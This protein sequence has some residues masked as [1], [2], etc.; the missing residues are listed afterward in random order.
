MLPDHMRIDALRIN[1][2]LVGDV[3]AEAQAV[4]KG[5]GREDAQLGCGF[6]RDVRERVGRIGDD[7][8][9]CVRRSRGW[10]RQGRGGAAGCGFCPRAS[11]RPV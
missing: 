7:K 6:A 1:V 2:E 8:Q 11:Q 10:R 5:A 9:R 4:E 3:N